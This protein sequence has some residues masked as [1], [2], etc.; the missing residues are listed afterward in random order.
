MKAWLRKHFLP[1]VEILICLIRKLWR[2]FALL[3]VAVATWVNLVAIPLVKWEVPNLTEA[4]AW[5]VALGGLSW[6]RE[7]GK[8][9]GSSE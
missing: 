4:A 8:A 6:V 5:L 3:G 1:P 9:K 2:P 7:W